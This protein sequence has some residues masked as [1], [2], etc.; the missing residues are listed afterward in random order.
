MCT[1]VWNA[2]KIMLFSLALII[3]DFEVLSAVAV[4]STIFWGI[5]PCSPLKISWCFRG[6]YMFATTFTRYLDQLIFQ[7]WIWRWYVTALVNIFLIWIVISHKHAS[8]QQRIRHSE[9]KGTKRHEYLQITAILLINNFNTW[10]WPIEAETC[11]VLK[12]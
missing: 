11:S 6:T 1:S 5:M 8:E 9:D 12:S 2:S 7:S 4:K 10:G 3:T